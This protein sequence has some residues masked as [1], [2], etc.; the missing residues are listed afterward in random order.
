MIKRY[1]PT[2]SG[3]ILERYFREKAIENEKYTLIANEFDKT[4]EIYKIKRNRMNI[5]FTVLEGKV[6]TM[7]TAVHLFDGYNIEAI[8][9]D[10]QD[11]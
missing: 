4:V 7:L 9:L 11:I 1:Y 2:F 3:V 10:M 8:G 6:K 5:D